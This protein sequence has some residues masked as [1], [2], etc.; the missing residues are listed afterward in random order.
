MSITPK[1]YR[2]VYATFDQIEDSP[3]QP[4]S[5]CNALGPM[6]ELHNS[7]REKGLQYPPLARTLPN[8]KYQIVEGH[9][10]K[11]VC[12]NLNYEKMPLILTE[13]DP[14]E[15][16]NHVN[17]TLKITA[18][19][20]IEV[21]LKG[22]E[23]GPTS[24]KT[25][26]IKLDANMGKEYLFKLVEKNISPSIWNLSNRVIKYLELEEKD[27]KKVLNWLLVINAKGVSTWISNQFGD[28]KLKVAM[29]TN[30]TPK[31]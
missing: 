1:E 28:E 12:L 11:K 27:R 17:K 18:Q 29:M 10:R 7:I 14:S 23:V 22:G 5:R 4:E 20:W 21:Y 8:N 19:Q 3:F 26:I 9:R 6:K 2:I 30:S 24:V 15:L 31:Y 16:F 13:G 25:C